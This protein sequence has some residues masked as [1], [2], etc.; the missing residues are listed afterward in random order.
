MFWP[1]KSQRL[2]FDVQGLHGF[3]VAA[4]S[5]EMELTKIDG[6]VLHEIDGRP[7]REVYAEELERLGLFKPGDDLLTAMAI[8]ELG[9]R[10]VMGDERLKIR[11]PLGIDGDSVTLGGSLSQGTL[12]RVVRAE[13]EQL[14]A[15]ASEL[16]KRMTRPGSL[17]RGALVF[18]CSCRWQLLGERYGEQ[19]AAFG[20]EPASP[21]L[22]FASYGEFAKSGGS[23]SGYH[24]TTAVMAAW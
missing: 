1:E 2:A 17:R 8:N 9:L 6:N 11:T 4:G 23:L 21:F 18:D 14:I 20:S 19:V 16:S 3:E 15:A 5:R 22:G 13:P 7:A 24:N 10:T 12:V